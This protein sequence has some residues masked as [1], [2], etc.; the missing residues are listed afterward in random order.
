MNKG[1]KFELW[2]NKSMKLNQGHF[3]NQYIDPYSFIQQKN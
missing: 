2:K 3:K 1:I